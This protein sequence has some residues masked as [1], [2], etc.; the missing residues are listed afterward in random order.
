MSSITS[1]L[2][3]ELESVAA[4]M[5]YSEHWDARWRQRGQSQSLECSEAVE[6]GNVTTLHSLS[7]FHPVYVEM[8]TDMHRTTH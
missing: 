4:P 3:E 6:T 5:V 1:R 8:Y 2:V 7:L